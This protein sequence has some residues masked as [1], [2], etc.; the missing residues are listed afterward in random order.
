MSLPRISLGLLGASLLLVFSGC[1]S[2]TAQPVPR[3]GF[4]HLWHKPARTAS[5]R[6]S[7]VLHIPPGQTVALADLP[8]PGVI[9]HMWFTCQCE[10][11]Q[12]YGLLVLRIH[13]DDEL[14][15]SVLTP[16]GDFFGVGFGQERKF[17]SR[18]A[19]MDP[20]GMPNH[21]ALNCYW[22]MP[23][24]RRARISIE[25]RAQ[26]AVSM[27]FMHVDYERLGA[28]PPDALYFHAHW[29]RENPVQLR[30]PY[31]VLE[32]RGRGCYV[33][34]VMNYHLLQPGSWVEG[35]DDFYID[36][37]TRPTLPGTGA[38]DYFGQAWGFRHEENT[39]LH[40]TS[41]G[42]DDNRMTAYRWHIPDPV[43]FDESLRVVFR[44]HGWQ[45]GARQDDY[46]SVAC[47]YQ[48]EPHAPLPELPPVDYDYL[49][50]AAEFREA[51]SA[52][53]SP[54]RL[55]TPPGR[56]LAL[57]AAAV[58]ASGYYDETS[59]PGYAVDGALPTKWCDDPG[60]EL[61]WLALDL[62][63]VRALSGVVVKHAGAAGDTAGFNTAAFRVEVADTLDGPW[64]G[65]LEVDND[66]AP[67]NPEYGGALNI[68]VFETPVRARCVRL[69]VTRA[70]LVD[71]IARIHEFEVYGE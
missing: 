57:R 54:E 18:M 3:C 33:G 8:G 69:T 2:P 36:G 24:A 23:F 42:P 50:V 28:L 39:A 51:V 31:T 11:P 58:R 60:R 43:W 14:E 17:K 7:R 13:W 53:Y 9:R 16:L 25:N 40:G 71:A 20:A 10:I 37:D 66:R 48:S 47:W 30:V 41:L 35:G 44:C 62:G 59:P 12:I 63:Q 45:V 61:A 38:E 29:R 67:P 52:R 27:F 56:N 68:A 34:T 15:P 22:P 5:A 19:D 26:R 6:V 65:V 49:G 21:A 4:D 64:R 55:P 32:A 46:A 1:Q 70:C